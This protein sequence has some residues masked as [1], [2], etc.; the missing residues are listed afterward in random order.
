MSISQQQQQQQIVDFSTTTTT[1]LCRF[2]KF[3]IMSISK[4]QQ[5]WCRLGAVPNVVG[6]ALGK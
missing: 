2:L 4:V 3:N 5:S 1:T 6:D